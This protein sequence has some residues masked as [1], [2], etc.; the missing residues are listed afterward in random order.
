MKF[1]LHKFTLQQI[2]NFAYKIFTYMLIY[3]KVIYIIDYNK[4]LLFKCQVTETKKF[5]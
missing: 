3:L 4:S 5:R 1:A 2:K